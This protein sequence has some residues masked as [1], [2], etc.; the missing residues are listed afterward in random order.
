VNV[1]ERLV[2]PSLPARE[3][4]TVI[5]RRRSTVV[6]RNRLSTTRRVGRRVRSSALIA[7]A[8]NDAVDILSAMAALT[9]VALA[10]YDPARLLA[11]DHYGGVVVGI[12]VVVTGIRVVRE[13]SLELV[14]TMPEP[15]LTDDIAR[16]ARSVDGVRGIDNVLARKSGLQHH[17][18]LHIEVDPLMTVA[19][20]DA[21]AG[22]VRARIKQELADVD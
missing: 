4:L 14:D 16:V 2:L 1:L 7:D 21:L 3:H 12:V 18:D 19:A 17:I 15:A 5:R 8:W 9:A 22:R 13:A 20:S 10:S 11:A 6:E